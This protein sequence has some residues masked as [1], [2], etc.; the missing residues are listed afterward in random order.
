MARRKIINHVTF[1]R[2]IHDLARVPEFTAET[3]LDRWYEYSPYTVPTKMM[4]AAC[5]RAQ[6]MVYIVTPHTKATRKNSNKRPQTYGVCDEWIA[7]NP[8]EEILK[9]SKRGRVDL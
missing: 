7:N 2:V 1:Y 5:L 9:K 3:I 6:P 4:V 8:L